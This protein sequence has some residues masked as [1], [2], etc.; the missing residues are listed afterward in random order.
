M[1]SRNKALRVFIFLSVLLGA[2]LAIGAMTGIVFI[3]P[4]GA[5]GLDAFIF[6]QIR[7][8]RVLLAAICGSMLAVSGAVLQG[9]LR[10]PLAD[11]YILGVSAGGGLGAALAI[12]AGLPAY[13]IS[14]SAFIGALACV[15]SVYLISGSGGR[16]RPEALILAGV[17]VS[18]MAGAVLAFMMVTGS[19]LQSIYF[20]MLGSFSGAAWPQVSISAAYAA[21]GILVSLVYART[22]NILS[23]GDDEALSLGVDIRTVRLIL[24][25]AS[26][27]LA[28]ASVSLCGMIGFAGLMVPHLVRLL[29]GNNNVLVVPLSALLG[30]SLMVA[31][32]I[33]SRVIIMPSEIPVGIVTAVI[34]APFFIYLLR[35]KRAER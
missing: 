24:L 23:L 17:A 14:F 25:A 33:I 28:G 3:G 1:A 6:W 26:S 34:G 4:I 2:V 22:M 7:L 16:K 10:N 5:S 12:T 21:I 29:A 27:L 30:A 13:L 19:K 11:P 32:D 15:Y 31:A 35:R 20:W 9:S 8:P 18:S